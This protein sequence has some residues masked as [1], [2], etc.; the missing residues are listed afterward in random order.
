[1]AALKPL[2]TKPHKKLVVSITG[3]VI[4]MVKYFQPLMAAMNAPAP[5]TAPSPALKIPAAIQLNAKPTKTAK[6]LAST[7]LFALTDLGPA[8]KVNV[9]LA[10]ASKIHSKDQ[11]EPPQT[12]FEVLQNPPA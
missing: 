12:F 11:T 2:N 7:L 8:K 5:M 6:P 10:A 1:M 9:T 3:F 4:A